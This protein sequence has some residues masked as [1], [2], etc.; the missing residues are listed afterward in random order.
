MY[1]PSSAGTTRLVKWIQSVP[2]TQWLFQYSPRMGG[3]DLEPAAD[4]HP[5]EHE[6]EE[7]GD[8][9]PNREA[10]LGGCGSAG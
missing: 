9:Q 8:A 4:K 10:E 7:V 6:V 1:C 3:Q 5:D 2:G